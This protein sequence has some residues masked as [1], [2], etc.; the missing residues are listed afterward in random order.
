[1]L[2]SGSIFASAKDDVA[3]NVLHQCN[4]HRTQ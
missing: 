2:L 3:D 4:K 1:M